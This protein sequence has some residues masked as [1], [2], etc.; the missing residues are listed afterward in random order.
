MCPIM[1]PYVPL[2]SLPL[3]QKQSNESKMVIETHG[4]TYVKPVVWKGLKSI[5]GHRNQKVDPLSSLWIMEAQFAY[6]IKED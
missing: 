3:G 2:P 4:I 1:F 5:K 6:R